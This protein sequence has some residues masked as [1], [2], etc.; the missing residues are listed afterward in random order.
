M[1]L[2]H[3]YFV[4]LVGGGILSLVAFSL[5]R[6]SSLPQVEVKKFGRWIYS[7]VNYGMPNEFHTGYDSVERRAYSIFDEEA[8]NDLAANEGMIEMESNHL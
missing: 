7:K 3:H 8:Q 4:D 2:T 1:Y 5:T 6:I